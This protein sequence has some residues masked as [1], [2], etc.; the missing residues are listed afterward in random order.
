MGCISQTPSRT[1]KSHSN[2]VIGEEFSKGTIFKD[3]DR[4]WGITKDGS[5][6][7]E[8]TGTVE[9]ERAA[10]RGP[11]DESWTFSYG[12][13]PTHCDPTEGELGEYIP[14]LLCFLFLWSVSSL[15]WP[16]PTQPKP[17]GHEASWS[18]WPQ[19]H[20][21][22]YRRM[23]SGSGRTNGGLQHTGSLY[24]LLLRSWGS[25]TIIPFL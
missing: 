4:R 17:E 5:G 3:M 25:S 23:G 18:R 9:R 14:Q 20:P 15:Y 8:I 22:G 2:W 11:L 21:T 6:E 7:G 13:Q 12:A 16:N 24:K 10:W 1:Q 19:S